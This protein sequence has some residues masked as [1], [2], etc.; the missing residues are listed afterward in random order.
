[1]NRQKGY[2]RQ[3]A[4]SPFDASAAERIRRMGL[5]FE[6]GKV[7]QDAVEVLSC[8]IAGLYFDDLCDACQE[9]RDIHSSLDH[10][11]RDTELAE[12]KDRF[13]LICLQYDAIYRALP[14]PIWWIS[15]NIELVELFSAGF[16]TRLR[17]LSEEY[18]EGSM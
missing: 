7:N 16:L 3:R 12:P 5:I 4:F 2:R 13:L 14:D 15:G 9:I 18:K 17:Q 6:D 11:F 8:V 1:M 10:L